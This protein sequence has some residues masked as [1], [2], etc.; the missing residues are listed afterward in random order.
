MSHMYSLF[1]DLLG[2]S[3]RALHLYFVHFADA[4]FTSYKIKYL[5][6]NVMGS[7]EIFKKRTDLSDKLK[8]EFKDKKMVGFQKMKGPF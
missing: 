4:C 3:L 1:D 8:R 5:Y 7:L 6:V 2:Y